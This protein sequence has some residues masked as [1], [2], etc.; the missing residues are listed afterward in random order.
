MKPILVCMVLFVVLQITWVKCN[1]A[2]DAQGLMESV[3][4]LSEGNIVD[5]SIIYLR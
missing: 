2:L 4:T 5:F 1:P 3:A